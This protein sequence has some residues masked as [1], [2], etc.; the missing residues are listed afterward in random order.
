MLHLYLYTLWCTGD[1]FDMCKIYKGKRGNSLIENG[2]HS[3]ISKLIA[4]TE[5]SQPRATTY[6]NFFFKNDF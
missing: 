3:S 5:H 6:S 2:S 4:Q 1:I